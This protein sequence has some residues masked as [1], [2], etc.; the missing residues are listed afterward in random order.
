[1]FRDL[2]DTKQAV[3]AALTPQSTRVGPSKRGLASV[4]REKEVLPPRKSAR[5]AGGKVCEVLV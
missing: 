4:R 2:L 5:L 1:M 3:S